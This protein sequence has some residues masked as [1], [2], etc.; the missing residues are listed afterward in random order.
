MVVPSSGT[1]TVS[2]S[3]FV[4]LVVESAHI[5]HDG[6]PISAEGLIAY[7]NT[8]MSAEEAP[9][10]AVH[11]REGV[12]YGDFVTAIDALRKTETKSISISLKEV[13]LGREV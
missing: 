9:Y 3:K 5:S 7:L 1:S 6:V 4:V 11:I 13:P 8:T 2:D 12:T 10:L